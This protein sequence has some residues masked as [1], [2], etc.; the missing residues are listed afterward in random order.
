MRA[1]RSS[2]AGPVRP[3]RR[4]ILLMGGAAAEGGAGAG[5]PP[6]GRDPFRAMRQQMVE[7]QIER[8]GVRDPGVL[9]A[10][11]A[12]PRERFV[13][14]AERAR[15]YEDGPLSIGSGQ[16][17]SQP[18][19]VAFM[20]E[21]AGVKKGDRV[22]EIGTGS[23][24][25]AAVLAAV[26]AEVWSMEILPE[27]AERAKR[28]LAEAGY[29]GVRVRTGDGWAGWPE[30]APFDAILV[31]AAPPKVA[32]PLLDQLKVGGKL[33]IPVGRYFQDLKVYTRTTDG[34]EVRNV[35]P[36]R[37]VPM[38]GQA[39]QPPPAPSRN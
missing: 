3:A 37:F 19:I 25:Q 9:A 11:R 7:E 28:D 18:Y 33:V 10:M 14:E 23:G 21:A 6:P 26:G 12:V 5:A 24:Y 39:Q 30:E 4:G 29:T 34:F 16:T 1:R 31:T 17:I 35:I 8:R 32:Q 38:T 27:L 36:V 20:T 15:A 22:L 13:P 2:I